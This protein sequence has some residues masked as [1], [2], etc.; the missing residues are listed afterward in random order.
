MGLHGAFPHGTCCHCRWCSPP[1]LLGTGRARGVLPAAAG[2]PPA[3]PALQAH[4]GRGRLHP[5]GCK[6]EAGCTLAPHCGTPGFALFPPIDAAYQHSV[7]ACCSSTWRMGSSRSTSPRAAREARHSG[8]CPR[9]CTAALP[10]PALALVFHLPCFMLVSSL[11]QAP[12]R[13]AVQHVMLRSRQLAEPGALS[14]SV[15]LVPSGLRAIRSFEFTYCEESPATTARAPA[16]VTHSSAAG[17]GGRQGGLP[18]ARAPPLLP[19]PHS[20]ETASIASG[21]REPPKC[22]ADH[23]GPCWRD[24]HAI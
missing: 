14:G 22:H 9:A 7:H 13:S 1:Q 5:G 21:A 4:C 12:P 18:A 6:G 20:N 24:E 16:R 11:A 17:G 10:C 15:A 23:L 19:I 3:R 2:P 8:H